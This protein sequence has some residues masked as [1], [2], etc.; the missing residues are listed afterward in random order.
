MVIMEAA[1]AGVPVIS[2]AVGGVPDLLAGGAGWLVPANDGGAMA[3]GIRA[4]LGDPAEARRRVARL[5]M[6]LAASGGE[7][8]W[9]TQYFNLYD[10]LT[11]ANPS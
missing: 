7:A 9:I 3:A 6:S 8:D 4:A 10:R 5:Q 2:T 1:T 11:S